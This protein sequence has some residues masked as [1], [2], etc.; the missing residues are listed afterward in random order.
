MHDMLVRVTI[1]LASEVIDIEATTEE[2]PYP[3]NATR[4]A[5]TTKN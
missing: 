1:D 4:L 5:R 2:M 3:A